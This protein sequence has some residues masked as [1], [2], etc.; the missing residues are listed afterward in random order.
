MDLWLTLAILAGAITL[1]ITEKLRVDVV[2]LLVMTALVVTGTISLS[3][4][5]SGFSNQATIMVAAMFVLSA[6]LQRN[7]AVA[8][9]GEVLSRIRHQ[10]LFLLVMLVLVSCVAAFVNNTATVAVFLPLVLAASTANRWAP[11]K[12]LI[13][14]SYAAQF[15]GVCTLIGTSTNLVASGLLQ[16]TGE[17]PI[18]MFEITQLSIIS[19]IGGLVVMIALAAWGSPPWRAMAVLVG[20]AVGTAVH[21]ALGVG[22]PLPQMSVKPMLELICW[23]LVVPSFSIGLLPGFLA[24]AL[25]CTLRSFGDMVA[26]QRANDPNWRRPNYTNIEAGVMADGLGTLCAGL[27]GTMGLNTYS[28]SVGL[29]VATEVKAR[30]VGLGV[31]IGWIA[32]AF[33]PGS[34]VLVMAIPR[35]VLGA[36]L[37][38][39]SAF[40]VLSGISILGQRLLDARRT[41]VVGLG[42]LIGISFDEIPDFYARALSETVQAIVT[43]SL[44]LGLF[45]ALALNALFRIG[46]VKS[47]RLV[48][49][50]AEGHAVLRQFLMD[51][52]AADGAR[53]DEV[54]RI[55]QIAEEF[56][57]AAPSVVEGPV[58]VTTRFDEFVLDVSFAWTGR[59]LQPGPKPTFDADVDEE[60]M[61]NGVTFLL[62]T[63]LSDRTHRRTLPDG[64]Q[65]LRCEVDQ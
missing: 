13:P 35:P 52:A 7:G 17:P 61:L 28:A 46:A 24:G 3:D 51:S 62:I 21:F 36:A 43:S 64:R 22:A 26:S 12:F 31:G 60:A 56:A 29:S 20:L 30:R 58:E 48:W 33:I 44:V 38:F 53:T 10:W 14:L 63:R 27:I 16:E 65:E 32:L 50:P 11:S 55:A 6:A 23:P 39:A 8:A 57:T 54:G 59:A 34:S 41:I 1:F 19:V 2:A 5:L 37:L 42:F 45:V 18:G 40:I 49:S 4:G 47:R 9:I 25:A 15:G